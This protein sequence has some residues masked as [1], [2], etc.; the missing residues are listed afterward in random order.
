MV[1][2]GSKQIVVTASIP[3]SKR[4][5]KYLTKKFLKKQTLSDFLH[6]I[7]TT[8]DGFVLKYYNIMCVVFARVL[9][10]QLADRLCAQEPRRGGGGVR[11]RRFFRALPVYFRALPCIA[12]V[13][14]NI[15]TICC[16]RG[17]DVWWHS[18]AWPHDNDIGMVAS[19]LVISS[20]SAEA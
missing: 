14:Y 10:R 16:V 2:A 17:T 6:P 1:R 13:L 8:K 4:Y 19:V 11:V 5:L 3:F 12:T 20:T 18:A 7:A 9:A 15:L